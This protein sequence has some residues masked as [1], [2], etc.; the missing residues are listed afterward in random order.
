MEEIDLYEINLRSVAFVLCFN[1][2]FVFCFIDQTR[3]NH[4][5]DPLL[6][7]VTV[8]VAFTFFFGFYWSHHSTVYTCWKHDDAAGRNS[9]DL[10][11][12]PT[13]VVYALHVCVAEA[14]KET[15]GLNHCCTDH[16]VDAL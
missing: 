12:P 10:R 15:P 2:I 11:P 14:P 9:S 4:T 16:V 7:F 1:N 3:P 13:A 8:I 6:F 5:K